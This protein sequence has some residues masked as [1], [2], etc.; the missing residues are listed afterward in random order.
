MTWSMR[1]KHHT[2]GDLPQDRWNRPPVFEPGQTAHIN[3][4]RADELIDHSTAVND[5]D[6]A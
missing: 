2:A 1:G 6:R 4:S 3:A 5:H